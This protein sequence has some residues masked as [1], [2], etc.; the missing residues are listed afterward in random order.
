MFCFSVLLRA[1]ELVPVLLFLPTCLS[2]KMV[3]VTFF[4]LPL[5]RQAQLLQMKYSGSAEL[6]CTCPEQFLLAVLFLY[7]S[8][9]V[10]A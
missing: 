10:G 5:A 4:I 9:E 6:G 2:K 8:A 7:L 3:I 1:T